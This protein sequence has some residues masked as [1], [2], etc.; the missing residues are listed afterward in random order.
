M[1][2]K[3]SRNSNKSSCVGV[4]IWRKAV[5]RR[6]INKRLRHRYFPASFTKFF[7]KLIL[8]NFYEWLL[9]NLFYEK[10]PTCPKKI[11]KGNMSAL[12]A[13]VLLYQRIFVFPSS[14]TL[15][16]NLHWPIKL[17]IL[18]DR[19]INSPYVYAPKHWTNQLEFMKS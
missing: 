7:R 14:R 18:S 11:R 4:S 16:R 9:T 15:P 1:F 12:S 8:K 3:I 10:K 5:R 6:V 19:T 2:L 13:L 17:Q